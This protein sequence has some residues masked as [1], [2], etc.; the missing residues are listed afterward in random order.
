[1]IGGVTPSISTLA[2]CDEQLGSCPCHL[3]P[4][5]SHLRAHLS[6]GCVISRA[7]TDDVSTGEISSL[8]GF[9]LNSTI[10]IQILIMKFVQERECHGTAE[11]FVCDAP[12]SN[13]RQVFYYPNDCQKGTFV[14]TYTT[15]FFHCLIAFSSM[16]F[17][18]H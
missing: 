13:H 12:D 3:T 10:R 2:L 11:D 18:V 15:V 4:R 17:P 8:P 14:L 9:K 7:G 6:G 16:E 1:M 5:A